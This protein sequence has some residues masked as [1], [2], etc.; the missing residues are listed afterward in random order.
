M[1]YLIL[2]LIFCVSCQQRTSSFSDW[3]GGWKDYAVT[4]MASESSKN[5]LNDSE[6]QDLLDLFYDLKS[7]KDCAERQ[8]LIEN[9][10]TLK[11]IG[12]QNQFLRGWLFDVLFNYD[13]EKAILQI[14]DRSLGEK[15]AF[16]V[17]NVW[18]TSASIEQIKKVIEEVSKCYPS[19]YVN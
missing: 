11:E 17:V 10:S 3:W 2:A 8:E 15:A 5:Y 7:A 16:T 13:Y 1:R 9:N 18:K 6:R 14:K 19:E 4:F 12:E